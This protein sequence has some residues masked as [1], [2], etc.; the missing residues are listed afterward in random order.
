MITG[1]STS[2]GSFAALSLVIGVAFWGV[3]W[4]PMRLLEAGGLHGLWLT[5]FLYS[6][7]LIAGLPRTLPHAGGFLRQ[8][9]LL[10][11]FLLTAGWCNVGFIVAVLEGNVLRVL[12]LFYLSPL[13]ATLL[14]RFFLG[15]RISRQ[16]SVSLAL[17][18]T[19]AI[20]MLWRPELGLPWPESEADWMA[21]SAGFCYAASSVIVRKSQ[22]IPVAG[23]VFY[24]WLS[25]VVVGLGMIGLLSVPPP[26]APLQIYGGAVALGLGGV[27]M[28][29]VLVQYGFTHLPIYQSAV[30]SLVELVAGALSQQL[31][32]DEIVTLHEWGGGAVIVVGSLLAASPNARTARQKSHP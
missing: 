26:Q 18:M 28:M 32:T 24:V 17:A 3:I 12:L 14:G 8:P 2:R 15:E 16:A 6:A 11:L 13:W 30:L 29:T 9:A 21:L 25:A 1:S 22:D 5:V 20:V 31:L 19:G 10:V 27:L 4:Y 7:A 23:K